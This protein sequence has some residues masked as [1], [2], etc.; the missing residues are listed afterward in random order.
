MA[1]SKKIGAWGIPVNEKDDLVRVDMKKEPL[2]KKV[3]QFTM[4]ITPEKG[5]QGGVLKMMWENAQFSV[6]FVNAK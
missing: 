5:G 4:S 2:D 6:N 3:D 1:F